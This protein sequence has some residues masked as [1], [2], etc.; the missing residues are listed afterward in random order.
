MRIRST[1]KDKDNPLPKA[2]GFLSN[3][4]EAAAVQWIMRAVLIYIIVQKS[5]SDYFLVRDE[6]ARKRT[7][8]KA[9]A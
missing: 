5:L 2:E 3:Y 8:R 4:Y 6:L 1:N 9:F 7:V